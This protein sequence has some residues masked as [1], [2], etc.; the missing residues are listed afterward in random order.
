VQLDVPRVVKLF[1]DERLYWGENPDAGLLEIKMIY[2]VPGLG[3]RDALDLEHGSMAH[4]A[5][6]AEEASQWAYENF[7][8]I[9][10]RFAKKL[11][12]LS[13]GRKRLD[14]RSTMIIARK[15]YSARP[16]REPPYPYYGTLKL[17]F[18]DEAGRVPIHEDLPELDAV[19]YR[20]A[21]YPVYDLES[22]AL[23]EKPVAGRLG[24]PA[25]LAEIN[26]LEDYV[27]PSLMVAAAVELSRRAQDPAFRLP[28]EF[29]LQCPVENIP[30]YEKLGFEMIG[31]RPEIP[32]AR[33]TARGQNPNYG[34]HHV[35]LSADTLPAVLYPMRISP[36]ALLERVATT[37]SHREASQ[38]LRDTGFHLQGF[39]GR[40][41]EFRETW[42][43]DRRAKRVDLRQH[44]KERRAKRIGEWKRFLFGR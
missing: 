31:P 18:A 11:S 20:E 25:Q 9:F 23:E 19:P 40:D 33:D 41:N 4:L 28:S 15:P 21:T 10:P 12:E 32:T 42:L 44:Q 29:V 5:S 2:E 1:G 27:L 22:G 30:K 34:R 7:A 6:R 26:S 3:K 13:V 39:F 36:R 38:D 17:F 43:R 8:G 16:Y 24:P 35:W 37:Q 14:H